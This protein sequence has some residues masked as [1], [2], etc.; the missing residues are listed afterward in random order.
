MPSFLDIDKNKVVVRQRPSI[1][2]ERVSLAVMADS[3]TDV[4]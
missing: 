1:K 2:V 3:A 4:A